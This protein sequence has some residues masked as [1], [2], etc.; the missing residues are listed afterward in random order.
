MSWRNYFVIQL[1]IAL[2]I[3]TCVFASFPD[4]IDDD[5]KK[6]HHQTA[7][8]LSREKNFGADTKNMDDSYDRADESDVQE[9]ENDDES[10]R[11]NVDEYEE[12]LKDIAESH[13]A[14]SRDDKDN[15]THDIN[16]TE[17]RVSPSEISVGTKN[18]DSHEKSVE[19]GSDES[20]TSNEAISNESTQEIELG[21]L[22]KF[23]RKETQKIKRVPTVKKELSSQKEIQGNDTQNN[24]TMGMINE[25]R[26][27][28][29]IGKAT[30][31]SS[32]HVLNSED[33]QDELQVERRSLQDESSVE[34]ENTNLDV[35]SP[36]ILGKLD[37]RQQ[38]NVKGLEAYPPSTT[39]TEDFSKQ[40]K[41]WKLETDE[42]TLA[43]SLMELLVKLAEN[44]RHWERTHRLLKDVEDDLKLS[45]ALDSIK[46]G[47][48]HV[49]RDEDDLYQEPS[50]MKNP[51]STVKKPKK[52][53][54]KKKKPHYQLLTT[55]N[56]QST[57]AIPPMTVSSETTTQTHWRQVADHLF[58]TS[59]S[60]SANNRP[61]SNIAKVHYA[62]SSKQNG[63]SRSNQRDENFEYIN[64]ET[65]AITDPN[66]KYPLPR[67]FHFGKIN[68]H[69]K[70]SPLNQHDPVDLS[71][72][73]SD[74]SDA[75]NSQV[76]DYDLSDRT[77]QTSRND[78]DRHDQYEPYINERTRHYS[79]EYL[80]DY[81]DP[82][83]YSA[84]DFSRYYD[85]ND[86]SWK[87]S[88]YDP[89]RTRNLYHDNNNKIKWTSKYEPWKTFWEPINNMKNK[90]YDQSRIYE[91]FGLSPPKE[92][93]KTLPWSSINDIQRTK[94]Y[95]H[96]GGI[97]DKSKNHSE[98]NNLLRF[99]QE[100]NDN[101]FMPKI[102]MKTWNSLTSDPATWPFK[103][104]D[105]KP[106]PKD[107]NGKSYN[108]NADLVR[109]L[110]LD[111]QERDLKKE[112]IINHTNVNEPSIK[113]DRSLQD[114]KSQNW[115][116]DRKMWPSKISPKIQ[117]VG[118]WIM[119]ADQS[120][121]KPYDINQ[122]QSFQNSDMLGWP[123][124]GING[125]W[126]EKLTDWNVRF[127]K[128]SSR[129]ATWPPKWKQFSYHKVNA[130][131]IAKSGGQLEG[132][133][134]T[135]NAFIAV[136]AV[137][138][139]K[140]PGNEWHKNDVEEIPI[141]HSL[142]N[143]DAD[144]PTT[145]L[146]HSHQVAQINQWKKHMEKNNH[147]KQNQ[148]DPLEYQLEELRHNNLEKR[149][150][151]TLATYLLSTVVNNSKIGVKTTNENKTATMSTKE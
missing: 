5:S 135:R 128:Q 35:A 38:S 58:G 65:S 145:Q 97:N 43:E 134:K 73:E 91:K 101:S 39:H 90:N 136:S 50:S 96:H 70:G 88:K 112:I 3:I 37:K 1:I 151:P 113:I 137:S 131:P 120:T 42:Y 146:L 148:T 114:N 49:N 47:Y 71:S 66:L 115:N 17:I 62:V 2:T 84:N 67:E 30:D 129:T 109:K 98:S 102:T 147:N 22:V 61:L 140:Y 95:S 81:K 10:E 40:R 45:R 132:A 15:S 20:M 142:D 24:V 103:L 133:Q 59:W 7:I 78:G 108:P 105:V 29:V 57:S 80:N 79:D 44:P 26:S 52:K 6:L 13:E 34:Y 117:S 31:I 28:N 130:A 12:E 16:Q 54:K 60:L 123:N 83:A 150:P 116:K 127:G 144:D 119:P 94:Q 122:R 126:Q 41:L 14:M 111:K 118:T 76:L 25:L 77:Y 11:K 74:T 55:S 149:N 56:V 82:V 110:G 63:A 85:Y 69:E 86:K 21:E 92:S 18:F 125:N 121:W 143:I 51:V 4:D 9:E 124:R 36:E 19:E 93:M 104:A 138:P 89:S 99:N 8:K 87:F 32:N 48:H 72:Y 106:W 53:K 23:K 100:E 75:S 141:T 139:S 46:R 64:D 68:T 107:K 27:E 33:T